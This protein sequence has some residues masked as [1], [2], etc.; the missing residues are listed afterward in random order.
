[1]IS[2]GD[3]VRENNQGGLDRVEDQVI[4][5]AADQAVEL[6]TNLAFRQEMFDHKYQEH[7]SLDA[8]EVYL[9]LLFSL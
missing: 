5:E 8:L 6:L 3:Q 1:V 4:E 2:P 9:E 7:F